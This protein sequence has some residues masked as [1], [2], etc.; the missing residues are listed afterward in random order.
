MGEP[1]LHEITERKAR[2]IHK[3]IECRRQIRNG[4]KYFEHK[5]LWD[6]GFDTLRMCGFC[7]K[8]FDWLLDNCQVYELNYSEL[9]DCFNLSN[10]GNW[11]W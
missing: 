10:S 1:I 8:I 7:Q 6:S 11:L 2:K 4:D 5:G 3:C 9:F